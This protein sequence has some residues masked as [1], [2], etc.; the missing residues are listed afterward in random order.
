MPEMV[1]VAGWRISASELK[2]GRRAAELTTGAAGSSA[3][4]R[5]RAALGRPAPRHCARAEANR[6]PAPFRLRHPSDAPAPLCRCSSG[7]S[8]QVLLPTGQLSSLAG[9]PRGPS[10]EYGPSRPL[11]PHDTRARVSFR[12]LAR[13]SCSPRASVGSCPPGLQ[14]SVF[15]RFPTLPCAQSSSPAR[16]VAPVR[17][18]R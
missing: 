6:T 16:L 11:D 10:G 12:S 18:F 15:G 17:V 8:A 7:G 1:S 2:S 9:S 5:W 3:I 4:V 13:S 14:S